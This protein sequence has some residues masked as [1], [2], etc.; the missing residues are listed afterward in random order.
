VTLNTTG[1]FLEDGNYT[2]LR[3]N[4]PTHVGI[5]NAY[6]QAEVTLCIANFTRLHW[7]DEKPLS[8]NMPIP[9]FPIHILDE[10]GFEVSVGQEGRV[11]VEMPCT[12]TYV[13]GYWGE[14]SSDSELN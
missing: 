1:A 7:F 11:L 10:Q 8:A 2:W 6:G 4:L 12:P 3:K 9:T 13:R 5:N 14:G